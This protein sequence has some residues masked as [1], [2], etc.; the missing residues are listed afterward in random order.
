LLHHEPLN[1]FAGGNLIGDF[2]HPLDIEAILDRATVPEHSVYFMQAISG[3]K[4]FIKGRYL[5]FSAGELLLAIGYPVSGEYDPNA[6]D[7]ALRDA[8]DQ[9]KAKD[10]MAIA[11]FLPKRL[12]PYRKEQD[13]YYVLPSSTQIAARIERL[14]SRPA[15]F[16]RLEEGKTFTLAHQ[17]LWAEFVGREPL[18]P[19]VRRLYERIESVFP[20]NSSLILLNAWTKEGHLAA[21]LLLDLAPKDFLSYIVGAHSRI[22]YTSYAS[23]FLFKEMIL[24]ARRELKSYLHL[25]LGVNQGI[26]RFKTKWGGTP[27]LPYELAAWKEDHPLSATKMMQI[28]SVPTK[29]EPADLWHMGSFPKEKPYAMLWEINKNG[30]HSWIGGTAHF[31]PYSFETSF[32]ELFNR[33]HTVIFEGPLDQVSMGQVTEAGHKLDLNTPRMIELFCEEEI[34]KLE[35]VVAGPRGIWAKL[36]GLESKN[37]PDVRYYLSETRPWLAFLTLW[38]SFLQRKGW[39]QSVDI[40]AWRLARDM[41]KVVF[42]LEAITEQI[43]ALESVPV[44]GILNFM[45]HCSKWNSYIH[46]HEKYYLQGDL[47]YM[48]NLTKAYPLRTD[49]VIN[50]RDKIFLQRMQPF[51]DKGGCV[52]FVGSAHM[53]DLRRMIAEAGYNIRKAG[54]MSSSG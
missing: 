33:V 22:H 6:F 37:A 27:S 38:C 36:L 31:F 44:Q 48:M 7:K 14:A 29:S 51:I 5:F 16:L 53:F 28:I 34:R 46:H 19:H 2:V 41:G 23:D 35:K 32:R 18:L 9:T 17:R 3:G 4:P 11:P 30:C 26:R 39:N 40:E 21:C 24:I 1:Q 10:C 52:V 54:K 50:Q 47:D 20:A 45:R 15:A 12:H 25:G 43:E 13:Q 49:R 8:V 42:G